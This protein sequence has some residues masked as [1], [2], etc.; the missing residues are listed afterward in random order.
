[1][2]HTKRSMTQFIAERVAEESFNLKLNENPTLLSCGGMF[3]PKPKANP[4]NA[5]VRYHVVSVANKEE[6]TKVFSTR[7]NVNA[8]NNV[9]MKSN[10]N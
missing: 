7:R 1:M 3:L 4:S 9:S 2:E 5:R 10:M 6:P 8:L